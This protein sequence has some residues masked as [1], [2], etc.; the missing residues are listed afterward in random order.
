M[1][2]NE[3][4]KL[5]RMPGSWVFILLNNTVTFILFMIFLYVCHT[6]ISPVISQELNKDGLLVAMGGVF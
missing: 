5:R 1:S 3:L 6:L 4:T 2:Y